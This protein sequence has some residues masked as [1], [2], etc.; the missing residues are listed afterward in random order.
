MRIGAIPENPVEWLALQTN[1]MPVPL[2]HTQ[3]HFVLSRAVLEAYS[4]GV[5]EAFADGS[6]TLQQCARNTGLDQRALRSLLNVLIAAG[7]LT[8][9]RGRYQLTKLSKK[10]CLRSSPDSLYDQQIFN[11][12]C[13]EWMDH[14]E[15]FLKSGRGLQFHETF[16]PKQWE[17]YQNG[18]ENV[19][20]SS[21][22]NAIRMLPRL[23]QPERFLDIGGSHGIYSAGLVNKY[24]TAEATILEL[25]QAVRAARRIL[26]KHYTGKAVRHQPGN[27]L[28]DPL[29]EEKYDLILMSSL[30]HHF[31]EKQ[32][33]EV[34]RKVA[35]ALKKG[36]YFVIQEFL[37][38]ETSPGMDMIGTVLDLYFNLSSTSGNWSA[39][40]LI[41][42]Q[43]KS[44]LKHIR[45]NKF[46]SPPGYTQV[47]AKK[48]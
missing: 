36:G 19:A 12:V 29:E 46:I 14:M 2:V 28:T 47:I 17:L 7:Y 10:W 26:K 21:A 31:T 4:L 3:I 23:N 38:P 45:I 41:R 8:F 25:P 5:F 16:T 32:N 6:R 9:S 27:V 20:R 43:E 42:F 30:M 44:G 15:G 40:E 39:S 1:R 35:R 34:S 33:M 37:R 48:T 13:W 18:M 24:P 11:K 22:Q